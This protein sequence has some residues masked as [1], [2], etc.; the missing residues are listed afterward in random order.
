[1]HS[2]ALSTRSWPGPGPIAPAGSGR[3]PA[4]GSR[5]APA[6]VGRCQPSARLH[7]WRAIRRSR[8]GRGL[9][10]N[11]LL[12]FSGWR[13]HRLRTGEH[14]WLRGR[15]LRLRERREGNICHPRPS[16]T[17]P[18]SAREVTEERWTCRPLKQLFPSRNQDPDHQPMQDQ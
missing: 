15:R 11:R 2:A 6:R 5:C 14:R 4:T 3:A 8:Y 17:A 1:M 18:A 9:R 12:R 10:W 16:A 13:H 7:R